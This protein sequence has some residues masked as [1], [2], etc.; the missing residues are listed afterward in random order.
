MEEKKIYN[1]EKEKKTGI[2][3]EDKKDIMKCVRRIK[4]K[5][6]FF[7]CNDRRKE[8]KKTSSHLAFFI[9]VCGYP[10]PN[11]VA[12]W[13]TFTLIFY[14]RKRVICLDQKAV[15][16]KRLSRCFARCARSTNDSGQ[17]IPFAK[18]HTQGF[19]RQPE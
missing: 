17:I 5:P 13:G 6:V 11:A 4:L 18:F 10:I 15:R 7:T 16:S 12:C 1:T 19:Q 3:L 9:R 2:W 8:I 14:G